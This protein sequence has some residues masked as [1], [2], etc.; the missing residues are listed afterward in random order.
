M[1]ESL[2]AIV[3]KQPWINLILGGKK[4]WEIRSRTVHTRGVIGLIEGGSGKVVGLARLTGCIGPMTAEQLAEH[5]SKH[6]VPPERMLEVPY[7]SFY[8][9]ELAGVRR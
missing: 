9:W 2:K 3:I 7:E 4:T 6:Q 5:F 8:A 1:E